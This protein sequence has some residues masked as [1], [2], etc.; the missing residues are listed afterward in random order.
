MRVG[1]AIAS[2]LA[3]VAILGPSTAQADFG[4]LPGTPGFD[5]SVLKSDSSACH[6]GWD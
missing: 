6:P 2:A 1:I 4:F 3:C 5:S